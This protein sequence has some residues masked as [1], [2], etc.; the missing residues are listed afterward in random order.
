MIKRSDLLSFGYYKKAAFTGS[1]G[2][3][4]FR[5]EKQQRGEDEEAYFVLAV[6]TWTGPFASDKTPEE[7]RT[8]VDFPFEEESLNSI[9]AYLNSF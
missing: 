6:I 5:I 4:R 3:L 9:C 7:E 2:K 8:T 1:D